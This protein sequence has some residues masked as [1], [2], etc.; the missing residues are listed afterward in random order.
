M[1]LY[2]GGTGGDVALG[3]SL[4]RLLLRYLKIRRQVVK[5]QCENEEEAARVLEV[6]LQPTPDG[7]TDAGKTW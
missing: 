5:S 1:E 4:R 7:E 2:E 6:D 3:I